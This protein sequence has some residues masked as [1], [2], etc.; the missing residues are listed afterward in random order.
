MFLRVYGF[1]CVL[2][3]QLHI[4]GAS[5]FQQAFKDIQRHH[6][7]DAKALDRTIE[8]LA[9]I[10]GKLQTEPENPKYRKIR[11]LNKTFW[12][13]VGSVDGGISFMSALGFDLEQGRDDGPSFQL[14]SGAPLEADLSEALGLLSARG[15]QRKDSEDPAPAAVPPPAPSSFNPFATAFSRKSR[16]HLQERAEQG[17]A[18]LAE[19]QARRYQRFSKLEER[20]ITVL[21]PQQ[22]E[23]TS[24][25]TH[26][27][28]KDTEQQ[29]LELVAQLWRERMAPNEIERFETNAAKKLRLLRAAKMYPYVIVRVRLPGGVYLQARFNSEETLTTVY[30]VIGAS[31]A[32]EAGADERR[33]HAFELFMAPPTRVLARD[34]TSLKDSKVMAPACVLHLRWE[35]AEAGAESWA[36]GLEKSLSKTSRDGQPHPRLRYS[37]RYDVPEALSS[38][39]S[40]DPGH[41]EGTEDSSGDGS[42]DEAVAPPSQ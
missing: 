17:L 6:V 40:Q 1:L 26:G 27:E 3:L 30:D 16:T 9:H 20:N 8:S 2:G 41:A 7:K 39:R 12:E 23:E 29:E 37:S 13:R 14:R 38:K 19:R 28:D 24:T 11:L 22:P 33:C 31:L 34:S 35:S 36:Q 4:L 5:Q 21:L 15:V 25:E 10:A 42:T 18:H 32:K